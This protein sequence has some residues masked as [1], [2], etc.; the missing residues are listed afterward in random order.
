M[1]LQS[2]IVDDLC[3]FVLNAAY[4][5]ELDLSWNNFMPIDFVTLMD[6]IIEKGS[7]RTLNLSWNLIIDSKD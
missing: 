5:E 4:L 3:K 1:K 2:N 6:C 7:L